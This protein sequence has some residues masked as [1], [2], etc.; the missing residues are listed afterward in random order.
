[1][2]NKTTCY[3]EGFIIYLEKL[4]YTNPSI[5]PVNIIRSVDC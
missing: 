2:R 3:N 5:T 1:M 4:H